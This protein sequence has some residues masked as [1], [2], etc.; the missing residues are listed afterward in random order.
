MDIVEKALAAGGTIAD[1]PEDLGFMY[2]TAIEDLDGHTW[3]YF[4]MDMDAFDKMSAEEK[5]KVC[6]A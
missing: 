3:N 2:S 4:C 5:Q 1:E 6:K